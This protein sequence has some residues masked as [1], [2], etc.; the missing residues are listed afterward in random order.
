M[1]KARY[2]LAGYLCLSSLA[3][4]DTV[5]APSPRAI[6]DG[7]NKT[8]A[9]YGNSYTHYNNNVNTRLRDLARSLLPEG[10]KGYTYRGITISTGH[11]GWHIPNLQ[12]QNGLQ[13]WDVVVF[14]GNSTETISKK[15]ATREYFTQSAIAMADIAHKANE[16]VVWFMTWA[17]KNKP[18]QTDKLE[19]AYLDIARQTHGY[20][21]PVGLAFARAVEQHPEI[22]LYHSDGNHPSLAGTYLTAC[23]LFATLYNHSPVGGALPVDSDMTERT[24]RALQQTAWDTVVAFREQ[25]SS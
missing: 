8:V 25:K 2:L 14:Q 1:K 16:K 12:F 6:M 4:A 11:L 9:I 10:G 7:E 19:K 18:E 13:K 20:V 15:A 23:V 3:L 22:N 17:S 24:A 21:A 5:I